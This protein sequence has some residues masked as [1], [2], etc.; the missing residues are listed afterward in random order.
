MLGRLVRGEGGVPSC[1]YIPVCST[2]ILHAQGGPAVRREMDSQLD[3]IY[4][5]ATPSPQHNVKRNTF[6]PVYPTDPRDYVL[7]SWWEAQRDGSLRT[8]V[9]SYKDDAVVPEVKG[10]VR[11]VMD[12]AG[13]IIQPISQQVCSRLCIH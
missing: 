4:D 5:V 7:M 12:I 9:T 8:Y 10:Y 1:A 3:T 2:P 13:W 6:K 11:G